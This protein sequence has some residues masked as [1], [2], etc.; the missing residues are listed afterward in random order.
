M[1]SRRALTR[2]EIATAALRMADG[3]GLEPLTMR[4]LAAELG[5]TAMA[6]YR[7]FPSKDALLEAV[8]ETA[9]AEIR[10]PR[11]RPS[12]WKSRMRALALEF[13]RVLR[14]HPGMVRLLAD[15]PALGPAALRL[16]EA[17]LRVLQESG[18]GKRALLGGYAALYGYTLGF[19]LVEVTRRHGPKRERVD[20]IAGRSGLPDLDIAALRALQPTTGRFDEVHFAFGL[21]VL[22]DGLEAHALAESRR[23]SRGRH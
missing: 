21:D 20:L 16:Y 22:L 14:N 4:A 17:S 10:P 18:L 15:R 2:A 6:L 7:H 23:R 11:A 19:S 8:V 3:H 1:G 13:R 9:L 12:G 5:I